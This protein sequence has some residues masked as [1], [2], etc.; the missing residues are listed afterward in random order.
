MLLLQ[1]KFSVSHIHLTQQIGMVK[2]HIHLTFNK[3]FF[4]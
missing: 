2:K 1:A 4:L 3:L